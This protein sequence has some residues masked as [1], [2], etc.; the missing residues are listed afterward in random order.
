MPF[1]KKATSH[2]GGKYIQ[3]TADICSRGRK[4]NKQENKREKK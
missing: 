4:L 3:H 2:G 1:F